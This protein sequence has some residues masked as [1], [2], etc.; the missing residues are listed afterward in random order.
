MAATTEH[1]QKYEYLSCA[2]TARLLRSALKAS[3]PRCTFSVTSKTYSG[4]ASINVGWFD[5]P[6]GEA[7]K[8]VTSRFSGADFDGMIDL[9]VYRYHWRLSDG[10][11]VYGGSPG[12][13]GSLPREEEPI[14][15]NAVA[16]VHFGADFI[17]ENRH[18][19]PAVEAALTAKTGEYLDNLGGVD[20]NY[21]RNEFWRYFRRFAEAC[22]FTAG[23]PIETIQ[24]LDT[25]TVGS[26]Y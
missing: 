9:K 21:K 24:A 20:D 1:A 25:F 4:G 2:D 14:P 7:V 23:D 3:W 13:T 5:G 17:F 12:S 18:F 16:K 11:I 22:D 6:T 15:I 26:G 8:A 10:S 19:S